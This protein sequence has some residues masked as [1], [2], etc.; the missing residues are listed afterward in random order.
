MSSSHP[1]PGFFKTVLVLLRASRK[2]AAGR[3]RRQN[4]LLRHRAS[5]NATDWGVVGLFALVYL[6]ILQHFPET[7]EILEESQAYLANNVRVRTTYAFI[8][9]GVA[10]FA[11]EYLFRGLLYRA[12]DREWGGRRAV[13]GSAAFF[14]IYHPPISWIP[15]GIVG[16]AAALLFK[17]TGS[18]IPA[19][20]LHLVYNAIVCPVSL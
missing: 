15:V 17:K 7:A 11:E 13:F 3:R 12:L 1:A 16:I 19:I 10:P 8:A 5:I 6:T 9:V 2:R 20:T 14:A 4:Q 18:L